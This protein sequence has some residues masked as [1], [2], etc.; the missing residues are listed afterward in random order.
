MIDEAKTYHHLI[1]SHITFKFSL[2][3]LPIPPQPFQD[4]L[5]PPTSIPYLKSNLS[6]IGPYLNKAQMQV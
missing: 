6:C 3:I 5:A 1:F 4:F 2:L